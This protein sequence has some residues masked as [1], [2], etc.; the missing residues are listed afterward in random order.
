MAKLP[1]GFSL[2]GEPKL[3]EGFSL[4]ESPKLPDSC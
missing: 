4:V 3:P 2:V 1:E